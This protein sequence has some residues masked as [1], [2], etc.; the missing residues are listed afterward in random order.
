MNISIDTNEINN[1]SYNY[2][3]EN[4]ENQLKE[5]YN[6]VKNLDNN[7]EKMNEILNLL[8]EKIL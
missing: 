7:I 8:K 1:S 6:I 3:I 5:I 2:K 4:M